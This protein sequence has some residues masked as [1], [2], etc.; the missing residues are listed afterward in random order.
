MNLRRTVATYEACRP[1]ANADLLAMLR[2]C[3]ATFAFMAGDGDDPA[4]DF[5]VEID[6]VLA[7]V[8]A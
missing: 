5:I 1:D 8:G 2:E 7:R 6:A 4:N 3:R